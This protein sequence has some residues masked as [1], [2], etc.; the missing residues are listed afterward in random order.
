MEVQY[1]KALPDKVLANG[2]AHMDMREPEKLVHQ[3]APSSHH[4]T[5]A[6]NPL[7]PQCTDMDDMRIKLRDANIEKRTTPEISEGYRA[8]I[9]GIR[10][11]AIILVVLYHAGFSWVPGGYIGVDVFF[12]LSGY[13]ITGILLK[14]LK[15][16]SNISFTKFYA[17]RA[18]RLLPMSVFVLLSTVFVTYATRHVAEDAA[19]TSGDVIAA[20]LYAANWQALTRA[21]DYFDAESASSP[22]L[23]FWSLSV[24]EQFYFVA[25]L[26]VFCVFM[27]FRFDFTRGLRSLW[28]TFLLL[29][30]LSFTGS[31]YLVPINRNIGYLSTHLRA[32]ELLA[33]CAL[34]VYEVMEPPVAKEHSSLSGAYF[35]AFICLLLS[36]VLFDD[37][38]AFPGATAVLPVCATLVLLSVG[39][40]E[41]SN[42]LVL[43]MSNRKLVFVGQISYSLYLWHWPMLRW[44]AGRMGL[45]IA[46]LP[47]EIV[48]GVL[49]TC[50]LV[51]WV[52]N[53]WIENPCRHSRAIKKQSVIV[54]LGAMSSLLVAGTA[55]LLFPLPSGGLFPVMETDGEDVLQS[56]AGRACPYRADG[57]FLCY[58]TNETSVAPRSIVMLGDSH[59]LQWRPAILIA[60]ATLNADVHYWSRGSC[61]LMTSDKDKCISHWSMVKAT[62][63]TLK[64]AH[65]VILSEHAYY[66]QKLL[67]SGDDD[68]LASKAAELFTYLAQYTS[69]IVMLQDNPTLRH[70]AMQTFVVDGKTCK[71]SKCELTRGTWP[72]RVPRA[73]AMTFDDV[74]SV[75]ESVAKQLM[76]TPAFVGKRIHFV[77]P[78]TQ[79]TCN[80][81]YCDIWNADGV[82]IYR[83]GNHLHSSWVK[84]QTPSWISFLRNVLDS[85]TTSTHFTAPVPTVLGSDTPPTHSEEGT[86]T[87]ETEQTSA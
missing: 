5:D 28:W 54:V 16:T 48:C 39:K 19:A 21:T 35:L 4:A 67:N 8:D 85:D 63:K 70:H 74:A 9:D 22:C 53:K 44:A 14:E 34:A 38:T 52:C 30:L 15:A 65:A 32:W 71:S 37:A 3:R 81:Q 64:Q 43:W 24:E 46:D 40:R 86:T 58:L 23:H 73:N 20:S 56:A 55:F 80:A 59:S 45:Q 57:N 78:T 47:V 27:A 66:A 25:P 82:Q 12:A 6:L 51:A 10:G 26:L 84:T 1:Y 62:F 76:R 60:A 17:R 69:N 79:Q 50:F 42:R 11:V 75:F 36:C 61:Q 2:D 13:L 29:G 49:L 33:G 87:E 72:C 41:P 31:L 7:D 18:K 83:D 77:D 68:A